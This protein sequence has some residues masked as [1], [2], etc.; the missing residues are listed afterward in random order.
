M[1]RQRVAQR[2][3]AGHPIGGVLVAGLGSRYRHDDAAGIEVA[4]RAAHGTDRPIDVVALADPVDLLG[5]WDH[6]GVVIVVD[7]VRTGTPP[8]TVQVVELGPRGEPAGGDDRRRMTSHGM[9]LARVLQVA[10]AVGSAP[11]RV[12]V[13]A[14]EGADFGRGEGL[15]PP[16]DAAVPEALRQVVRLAEEANPCV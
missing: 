5:L 11:L 9:G 13:V 15:S 10:R 16:V 3:A 14:I 6:T 7:A 1:T 2:D 12:V 4:E 8:G